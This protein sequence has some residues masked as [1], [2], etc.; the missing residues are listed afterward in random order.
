MADQ[1][2]KAKDQ[3]LEPVVTNPRSKLLLKNRIQSGV[4]KAER[5]VVYIG[6]LPKDFY[7]PDLHKF[8]S[9]FGEI[10]RLRLSRSKNNAHSKGYAYIEYELKE[11]AEVVAQEMN[12]YFIMSQQIVCE[13]MEKE[14]LPP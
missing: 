7:E 6:R 9:Q 4:P 8:F 2:V 14:K 5:G 1:D 3:K 11:V 13:L 10:T 12:K